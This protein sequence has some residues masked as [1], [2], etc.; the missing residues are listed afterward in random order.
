MK[1]NEPQ[2][3]LLA[4]VDGELLK[5]LFDNLTDAIRAC[6]RGGRRPETQEDAALY[7]ALLWA[8][9]AAFAELARRKKNLA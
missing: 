7:S 1:P 9:T 8:Q 3:R 2:P 5:D 4:A 6:R